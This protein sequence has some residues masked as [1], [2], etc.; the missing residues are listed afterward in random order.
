V[1][2]AE[3]VTC[4][5][6]GQLDPGRLA[7]CRLHFL[8]AFLPKSYHEK[9]ERGHSWTCLYLHLRH[10]TASRG[11]FRDT[12]ANDTQDTGAVP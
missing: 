10:G 5:S 4:K 2:V 8:A 3:V 9:R 6:G 12:T 7:L 1:L 11:Y